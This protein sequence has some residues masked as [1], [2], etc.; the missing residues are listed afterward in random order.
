MAMP[1]TA[2]DEN[3]HSPAPEDDVGFSRQIL[4]MQ[5]KP[6]THRMQEPADRQLRAGIAALDAAHEGTAMLPAYDIE[7]RTRLAPARRSYRRA[8]STFPPR[9]HPVSTLAGSLSERVSDSSQRR[10]PPY[11]QNSR[12]W[13]KQ[14]YKQSAPPGHRISQRRLL[15]YIALDESSAPDAADRKA[16]YYANRPRLINTMLDIKT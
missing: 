5:P 8:K 10:G 16:T 14:S 7:P 9:C 15:L 6:V 12:P 2:V 1:E 11:R 13:T 4:G 3:G